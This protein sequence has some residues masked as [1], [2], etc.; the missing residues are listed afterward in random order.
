MRFNKVEFNPRPTAIIGVA[1]IVFAL[2]FTACG[3]GGA[4][5]LNANSSSAATPN[6]SPIDLVLASEAVG[7]ASSPQSV[8]LSNSGDGDLSVTGLTF[9]GTNPTDFSQT[10]NCGA[11]VAAGANCTIK[12]IFRPLGSGS[13][14]ANLTLNNDSSTRVK[15][16]GTGIA[17]AVNLS[18]SNLTFVS[19]AVNVT[20]VAQKITV[21]NSGTATL[22]MTGI[23]ISGTNASDFKES[24]SCGST[25]AANASCSLS[26]SFKPAAAGSRTATVTLTDDAPDS[27]QTAALTGTIATTTAT[28]SPTSVTFSSQTVNS[29]SSAKTITLTNT[30]A[31]DLEDAKVSLVGAD[32]SDFAQTNTCG[33]TLTTGG[34]CTI[35]VTFKPLAAG[36]RTATVAVADSATGSPQTV[37]LSG[38]GAAADA[39]VSPS[40]VSYGNEAVSSNSGSKSVTLSNTGNAPLSVSSIALSGANAS[41]FVQTNNCGSSVAASSSCAINVSFKPS[42]SGAVTASLMI[43]DSASATP[44]SVTL[45]GTGTAA[46]INVSSSTI[47]FG[48]QALGKASA[49]Q[50]V[51]V[52][53]PG[54][55]AFTVSGISVSGANSSDFAQTNTCGSSVAAGASCVITVEFT[56]SASGTRAAAINI[57]NSVSAQTVT[58][59]GTGAAAGIDVSPS[60]MSFGSQALGKSAAA[61]S[62]T[63]SNSGNAALT[64]SSVC[65]SR[66]PMSA[67]LPR[68]TLAAR[69]LPPVRAA[70]SASPS[71]PPREETGPLR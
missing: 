55:A 28:A 34:S 66:V 58:L 20:A 14:N 71:R 11:T 12:I 13:R 46:A 45:S 7:T 3:G 1:C 69:A 51:T 29:A 21:T 15:V 40:T 52:S 18:P 60:S 24:D 30:G 5:S 67:T 35:N 64:V 43:A 33:S 70:V 19:T 38:T 16:R 63:L 9:D 2:L 53:N 10:N 49:A 68:P 48:N 50:S 61:Q 57:S 22:K 62:I 4:N 25:L 6:L 44:E 65:R 47:V 42:K 31:G 39:S 41:D 26:V 17:P 36:T 59:T 32:A 37:T 56:P 54:N 8:T 27:P 23:A